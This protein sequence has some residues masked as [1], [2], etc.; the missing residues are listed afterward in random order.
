MTETKMTAEQMKV[1]QDEAERIGIMAG[2]GRH[3]VTFICECEARD[4][5]PKM[6]LESFD[7][8]NST[9]EVSLPMVILWR[10]INCPVPTLLDELSQS[11]GVDLKKTAE[12]T[13]L[14]SINVVECDEKDSMSRK[15]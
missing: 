15:L 2:I 8:A 9:N 7:I 10:W 5:D 1:L 13:R 14:R 3:V 11:L 6:A 4:V 12:K